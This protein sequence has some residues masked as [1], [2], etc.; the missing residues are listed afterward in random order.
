M[1]QRAKIVVN[2]DQPTQSNTLEQIRVKITLNH[3]SEAGSS[4]GSSKVPM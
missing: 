3:P 2:N 1:Q 4:Q